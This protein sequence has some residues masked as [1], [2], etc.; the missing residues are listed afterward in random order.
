[1]SASSSSMKSIIFRMMFYLRVVQTPNLNQSEFKFKLA[2][3]IFY[4][5]LETVTVVLYNVFEH[6]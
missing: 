1:M 6:L 3:K 2:I 4:K 5:I